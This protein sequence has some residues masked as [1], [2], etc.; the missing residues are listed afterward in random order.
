MLHKEMF[1]SPTLK[2]YID[3]IFNFIRFLFIYL[4]FTFKNFVQQI[5]SFILYSLIFV[6]KSFPIHKVVKIVLY[7]LV[8]GIKLAL[9]VNL[10][11]RAFS[12]HVYK[13]LFSLNLAT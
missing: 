9:M 2:S 12:S 13:H 7:I 1:S 10:Y 11:V 4:Y 3:N 8:R 5:T 6:R